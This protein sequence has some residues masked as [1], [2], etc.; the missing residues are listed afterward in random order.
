MEFSTTMDHDLFYDY[1]QFPSASA[2]RLEKIY[3]RL[4]G[5]Y[6]T[7][8]P[9]SFMRWLAISSEQGEA[10][11]NMAKLVLSLASVNLVINLVAVLGSFD[12]DHREVAYRLMNEKFPRV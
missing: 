8:S 1:L 11:S 3:N 9:E 7:S 4:K 12:R 2:E 10:H 6:F 5:K